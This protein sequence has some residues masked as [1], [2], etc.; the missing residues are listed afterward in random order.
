MESHSRLKGK[1][2]LITGSARGI[3]KAIA[4]RFAAEGATLI[5]IHDVEYS[6]AAEETAERV[7]QLGTQ[8]VV[9][10]ADFASNPKQGSRRLWAQFSQVLSETGSGLDILVNNAGISPL[11][12][13]ADTSD[14]LYDKIMAV[15][16]TA[17][18][19]LIQAAGAEMRSGGSII[20][21]SSARTRIA[22]S[23]RVAYAASKG[24]INVLTLSL[25]PEYGARDITV[26]AIAPG[27]IDTEMVKEMLSDTQ[28]RERAERYS[29][30]SRL[31]QPNDIAA[32]AVF[33][34]SIE[35]R[36]VTGQVLDV[37]GGSC[38]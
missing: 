17:P 26:N 38:L 19:F 27:V 37:S 9:I 16:V 18:F 3:G 6:D 4:E 7:R 11:A 34:A 25:A 31:G 20:N 30:F 28:V 8:A 1:T 2:A 13:I 12:T 35:G 5:G 23:N 15:N 33:L 29:V 10:P 32:M 22:A 14:E 21:I 36:W 24:A